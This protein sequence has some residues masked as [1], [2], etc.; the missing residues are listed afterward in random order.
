MDRRMIAAINGKPSVI[1]AWCG[2]RVRL[3]AGRLQPGGWLKQDYYLCT[4][5][6]KYGD[7]RLRPDPDAKLVKC[8]RCESE[9]VYQ[10]Y[11]KD[12]TD[13]AVLCQHCAG[14]TGGHHQMTLI[15]TG[16][17]REWYRVLPLYAE[18]ECGVCHEHGP[19]VGRYD[20]VPWLLKTGVA[21]VCCECNKIASEV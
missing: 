19:C 11:F 9:Y 4:A 15:T 5:C 12:Q 18:H 2:N 20:V 16:A 17:D 3:D 13:G 7:P 8:S 6:A 14:L 10:A 21:Y 1:C